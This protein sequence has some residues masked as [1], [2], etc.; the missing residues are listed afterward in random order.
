[1]T[2]VRLHIPCDDSGERR[3]MTSISRSF[4]DT[5]AEAALLPVTDAQPNIVCY[6]RGV[7]GHG[8]ASGS[9]ICECT[10]EW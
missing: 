5:A 10:H 7:K 3:V 1:M 2:V 4:S 8:F 9:L 6:A